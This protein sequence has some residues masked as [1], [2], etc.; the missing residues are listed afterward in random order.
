M[1]TRLRLLLGACLIVGAL[2]WDDLKH[3]IPTLPDD[4]NPKIIIEQPNDSMIGEWAGVAES[5]TN[6]ED[7][8]RLCVFNKIFAERVMDYEAKAQQVNDIYVFAAKDLFGETLKGKYQELGPA[9]REAMVSVL[10][11][12]NHDIVEP[13]KFDLSKK[14][15]AFAWCLNNG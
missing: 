14:F 10:G 13:E 6:P 2:F 5:I 7:K 15:M 9:V 12:E 4:N 3:I 1:N 8:V 11:E